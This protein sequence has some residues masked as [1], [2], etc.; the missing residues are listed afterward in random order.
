MCITQCLDF[1][2]FTIKLR[3]RAFPK[4][5]AIPGYSCTLTLNRMKAFDGRNHT[6]E[7]QSGKSQYNVQYIMLLSVF[8]SAILQIWCF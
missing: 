3:N 8:A 6:C 1:G 5:T 4:Q 7:S 2:R